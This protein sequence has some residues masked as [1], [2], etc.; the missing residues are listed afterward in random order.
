MNFSFEELLNT[1]IIKPESKENNQFKYTEDPYVVERRKKS[2]PPDKADQ[3]FISRRAKAFDLI[4]SN[5]ELLEFF[6]DVIN[7]RDDSWRNLLWWHKQYFCDHF[8]IELTKKL[9]SDMD[10]EIFNG[11]AEE[12]EDR[13]N[14][15]LNGLLN[16]LTPTFKLDHN[17][18]MQRTIKTAYDLYSFITNCIAYTQ[19]N[20][21]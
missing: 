16:D 10:D 1:S 7:T 20:H 2:P 9:E 11:P 13:F 3:A 14:I 18:P 5:P 17:A 21:E 19:R 8:N 15:F 4:F 6:L 12:F